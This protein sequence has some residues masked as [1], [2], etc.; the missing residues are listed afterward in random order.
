MKHELTVTI[1]GH[2]TEQLERRL[3]EMLAELKFIETDGR[4]RRR[5]NNTQQVVMFFEHTGSPA[6]WNRKVK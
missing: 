2:Q 4:M 3:K 1:K 6:V 5:I